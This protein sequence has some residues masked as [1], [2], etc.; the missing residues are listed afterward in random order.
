MAIRIVVLDGHTLN[1]G[2]L[3]WE[4]VEA[5][6]E[7]T[8]HPRTAAEETVARC[9]GAQA[10]LTNKVPLGP[11]EF[12][13]LPQ[14]RYVGV[15]A[16]GYNIVDVAEAER[17]GITVTNVPE[18]G[19]RSVAQFAFALIL[20]LAH[21]VGRH[22]DLARGGSWSASPDFCFWEGDLVEL[23]GL[24]LGLIGYGRIG[25]AT[26]ALGTAFG[27]RVL[28][29]D[30]SVAEADVPMVPLE[31]L[32][33][34]SDVVSLHCPLTPS[35]RGL[36]DRAALERMKP[37]AWLINTAR[38]PLVNEADLAEALRK[39]TIA[40]AALDV[41]SVEP[42][43]PDNPLLSAPNCIVTPHIA[44]ATRAARARLMATVADNL[45]A[46]LEG[47]P[48]NVVPA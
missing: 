17:R 45:R 48:Q 5:L 1:P 34:E 26:A 46:F 19:T 21:R 31:R 16:T 11:A 33:S 12:D 41:L 39:G 38:G 23:E 7:L 9:Q 25:R 24:T 32:L 4:P 42:P 37:T 14:L 43:S 13:R 22:S 15:L 6:G 18:Y 44:W 47:R 2:D 20:E 3:S 8:V 36:I 27:M 10:V 40:G 30:P 28:A 29:H 35:N